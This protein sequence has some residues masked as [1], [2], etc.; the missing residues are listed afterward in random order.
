MQNGHKSLS[1]LVNNLNP[2]HIDEVLLCKAYQHKQPF[3]MYINTRSFPTF[4][5]KTELYA[6]VTWSFLQI[7]QQNPG[8]IWQCV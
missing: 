2:Y 3:D 1:E 5:F 8:F 4:V 7:P 6:K